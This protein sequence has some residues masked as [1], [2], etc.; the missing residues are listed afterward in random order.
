M[1][2]TLVNVTTGMGTNGL[3]RYRRETTQRT[4]LLA[5]ADTCH[6]CLYPTARP[7]FALSA[8]AHISVVGVTEHAYFHASSHRVPLHDSFF[9]FISLR[10]HAHPLFHHYNTAQ[11]G[12]KAFFPTQR[13]T[14]L[15]ENV[16]L[17]QRFCLHHGVGQ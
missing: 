7:C 2:R 6:P 3:S 17:V 5:R 10:H 4:T 14:F 11:L 16:W 8:V 9:P 1:G 15:S 13:R 12:H